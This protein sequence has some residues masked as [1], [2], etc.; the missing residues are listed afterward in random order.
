[1]AKAKTCIGGTRAQM[2]AMIV[3]AKTQHPDAP[4]LS[5]EA[6]V[7]LGMIK[8]CS[9]HPNMYIGAK[10]WWE[11]LGCHERDSRE[12]VEQIYKH[13]ARAN[14]PDGGGDSARMSEINQAIKEAREST[15]G[16]E[17]DDSQV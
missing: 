8:H 4:D 3:V 2:E 16:V 15:Q 14:H 7:E 9:V 11:V 6:L 17:R 10:P 5:V 1:M 13:L 12:Q